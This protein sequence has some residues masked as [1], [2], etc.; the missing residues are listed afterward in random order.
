MVLKAYLLFFVIVTKIRYFSVNSSL[1]SETEPHRLEQSL[2]VLPSMITLVRQAHDTIN[3]ILNHNY[4]R[5]E[6]NDFKMSVM[7]ESLA[8][9]NQLLPEIDMNDV[10][11]SIAI[12]KVTNTEKQNTNKESTLAS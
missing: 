7:I 8:I 1:E 10:D 6:P 11:K 4:F 5:D 12:L 9:L 2:S 3:W